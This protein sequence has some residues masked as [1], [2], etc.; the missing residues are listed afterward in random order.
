[1]IQV[2]DP[3]APLEAHQRL[4]KQSKAILAAFQQAPDQTL[5]NM[6][7]QSIATRFGARIYDLRRAGY[8]IDIIGTNKKTGLTT[9]RLLVTP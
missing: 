3:N 4:N 9:Y 1:M 2:C 7:M 6:D 8:K 5:T